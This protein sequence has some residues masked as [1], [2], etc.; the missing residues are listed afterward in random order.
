MLVYSQSELAIMYAVH[1]YIILGGCML[2][3]GVQA[4]PAGTDFSI[5][6]IGR[7]AEE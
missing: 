2:I 3:R 1:L 4:P 7:M 6:D 5:A